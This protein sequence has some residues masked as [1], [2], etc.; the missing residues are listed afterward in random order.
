[1]ANTVLFQLKPLYWDCV[2]KMH[3]VTILAAVLVQ[4][5]SAIAPPLTRLNIDSGAVVLVGLGDSADFAHQFHIAFSEMVSGA[6]IF[7]GQPF[8][9]AVSGNAGD[10]LEWRAKILVY[11][12]CCHIW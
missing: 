5:V 12:F 9:C 11:T 10:S 8:H 3:L 2:Y 4:P 7:S 1:M 6:C